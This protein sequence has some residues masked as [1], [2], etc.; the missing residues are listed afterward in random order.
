MKK[1]LSK[2]FKALLSKEGTVILTDEEKQQLEKKAYDSGCLSIVNLVYTYYYFKQKGNIPQSLQ[3]LLKKEESPH[4]VI[5]ILFDYFNEALVKIRKEFQEATEKNNKVLKEVIK[6]KEDFQDEFKKITNIILENTLNI[7]YTNFKSYSQKVRIQAAHLIRNAMIRYYTAYMSNSL[8]KY[9]LVDTN[10]FNM[11]RSSLCYI[12]RIPYDEYGRAEGLLLPRE[13]LSEIV[14]AAW[15]GNLKLE[16]T[17]FPLLREPKVLLLPTCPNKSE[18][19]HY[20]D[21][22]RHKTDR[23]DPA[24]VGWKVKLGD[25]I[26]PKVLT[27]DK[28]ILE[29]IEKVSPSEPI[30]NV[31][32]PL[33]NLSSELNSIEGPQIPSKNHNSLNFWEIMDELT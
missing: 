29:V 4:N 24:I 26:W 10:F 7:L 33:Q 2:F 22:N 21:S 8:Q 11:K 27:G 1:R 32:Q 31:N 16:N 25:N 15:K 18:F 12:D 14:G 9:A 13:I 6:E 28:R 3:E 20:F 19:K 30:V 23:A 17:I 5:V